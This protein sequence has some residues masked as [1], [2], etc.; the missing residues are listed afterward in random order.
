MNKRKDELRETKHFK[1]IVETDN[2][3]KIP[4][5]WAVRFELSPPELLIYSTIAHA[6]KYYEH[7]AFIGSVTSLCA[8]WNISPNTV[9]KTLETL[10]RRG[11]IVKEHVII[12]GKSVIAY[13]QLQVTQLKIDIL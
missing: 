10:D 1:R 3:I 4:S 12:G 6:T 13:R 7:G 9:R 5:D 11:M 2:F 8:M